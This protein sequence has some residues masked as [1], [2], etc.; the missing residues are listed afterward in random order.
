MNITITNFQNTKYYGIYD[1]GGTWTQADAGNFP[2]H[3]AVLDVIPGTNGVYE[4]TV[5]AEDAEIEAVDY[6]GDIDI[7]FIP[8][9]EGDLTGN[10]LASGY[11]VEEGVM[12]GESYIQAFVSSEVDFGID[13]FL[14]IDDIMS[15]DT[16]NYDIKATD[17]FDT[18]IYTLL[19]TNARA[20]KYEVENSIFRQGWIGDLDSE[21]FRSKLWLKEQ[22]RETDIDMSMITAYCKNA[23]QYMVENKIC[24]SV[25]VETS[26]IGGFVTA[27]IQIN[28]GKD[29]LRKHVPIWRQ[30]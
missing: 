30:V 13:V 9:E 1:N 16:E 17:S 20:T 15:I 6:T 7:D 19:F 5:Y 27:E 10:I 3:F 14:D 22:S 23:L 24:D 21:I 26:V 28:V 8:L 11:T 25:D 29:T 12:T 4:G 18:L 2:T